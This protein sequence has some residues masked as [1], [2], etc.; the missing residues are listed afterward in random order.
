MSIQ[1]LAL[2]LFGILH[3][4]DCPEDTIFRKEWMTEV[5]RSDLSTPL[6]VTVTWLEERNTKVEGRGCKY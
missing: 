3:C 6:E 4:I 5:A 1:E 2:L